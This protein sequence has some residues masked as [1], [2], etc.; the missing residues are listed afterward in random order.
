LRNVLIAAWNALRATPDDTEK[1]ARELRR[2]A[3]IFNNMADAIEEIE[4]PAK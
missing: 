2:N 4:A 1:V 3:D